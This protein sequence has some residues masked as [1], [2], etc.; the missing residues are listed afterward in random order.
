MKQSREGSSSLRS[1]LCVDFQSRNETQRHRAWLTFEFSSETR[2]Q[3]ILAATIN[4]QEP[5]ETAWVIVND[6]YHE[7]PH[8]D[9]LHE[10]LLPCCAHVPAGCQVRRVS[11]ALSVNGVRFRHGGSRWSRIDG[12][13][14]LPSGTS[15]R[16]KM[17][18][19]VPLCFWWRG[20]FSHTV[21]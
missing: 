5:Q 11:F 4:Q 1:V 2:C 17:F 10:R 9:T 19:V 8:D 13:R 21:T 6:P 20:R 14:N 7:H 18:L 3:P 12:T 15:G 16:E